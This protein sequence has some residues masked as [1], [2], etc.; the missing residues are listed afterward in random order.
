MKRFFV[1]VFTLAVA[2][3]LCSGS[4]SAPLGSSCYSP[5]SDTLNKAPDGKYY[6]ISRAKYIYEPYWG[7][8]RFKVKNGRLYD[9]RFSIRDS[10]KHVYFDGKYE[11]YFEG[12]PEY[13]QQSRND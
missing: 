5:S 10:A 3:F 8:V 2:F 4:F 9:I 6:G 13:I 12:N 11:K 1:L 7:I